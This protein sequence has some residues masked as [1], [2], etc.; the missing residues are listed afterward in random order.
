[1]KLA[2]L[3]QMTMPGAPTIYYG[4]EVGVTGDDDPDDRRTYPWGDANTKKLGDTRKPDTGLRDYYKAS[5]RCGRTTP[6]CA[7]VSWV[8]A[9]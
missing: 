6:C 2:A 5:P 1:M 3:I 7:T 4:D 9:H 8:P